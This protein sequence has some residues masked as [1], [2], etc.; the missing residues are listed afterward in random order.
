MQKMATGPEGN[1]QMSRRATEKDVWIPSPDEKFEIS[2]R[3]ILLTLF[4]LSFLSSFFRFRQKTNPNYGSNFENREKK[5]FF[6]PVSF[7]K[8]NNGLQYLF[9][10]DFALRFVCFWWALPSRFFSSK[11]FIY[12]LVGYIYINIH[13]DYAAQ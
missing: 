7:F 8:N 10:F 5:C 9:M 13:I 2:S 1:A 12:K 6:F 11:L 3:T 4:L